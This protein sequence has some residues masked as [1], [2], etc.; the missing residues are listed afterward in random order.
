MIGFA[1]L[2]YYNRSAI[3]DVCFFML[4]TSISSLSI[5]RDFVK[6]TRPKESKFVDESRFY[7]SR[8]PT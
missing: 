8:I 4:K 3:L 7:P 5:H 2:M 6:M 1:R